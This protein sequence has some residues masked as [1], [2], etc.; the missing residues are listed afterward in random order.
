MDG[1]GPRMGAGEGSPS[2][3]GR[4]CVASSKGGGAGWPALRAWLGKEH[5]GGQV[6]GL[7]EGLKVVESWKRMMVMVSPAAKG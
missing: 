3:G 6:L 7:D 2:G 5:Q 1:R 4:G